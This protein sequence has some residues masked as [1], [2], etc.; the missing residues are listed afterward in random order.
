MKQIKIV[1]NHT[2]TIVSISFTVSH[3]KPIQH[4]I[5]KIINQERLIIKNL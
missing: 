4:L 3:D 1:L 5:T 2:I